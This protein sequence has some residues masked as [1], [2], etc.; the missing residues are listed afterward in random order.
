[1]SAG[2]LWTIRLFGDGSLSDTVTT[3]QQGAQ[4]EGVDGNYRVQKVQTTNEAGQTEAITLS[5]DSSTIYNNVSVVSERDFATA[6]TLGT[7]LRRTEIS[8]QTGSSYT[9]RGL[10]HLPTSVKVYPGGL[11]RPPH[12]LIMLMIRL[13]WFRSPG[14]L[15]IPIQARL[16]AV[17]SQP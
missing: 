17:M 8:Y 6:G 12:A 3:W 9:S 5:Y 16:R 10:F 13:L 1:V 15:C 7:E 2:C 11:T 4:T 14:S